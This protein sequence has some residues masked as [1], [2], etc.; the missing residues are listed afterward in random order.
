MARVGHLESQRSIKLSTTAV[1][2]LGTPHQG[3]RGVPI[4]QIVTRIMSSVSHTNPKLLDRMRPNSDWLLDLQYR[5]NAISQDFT[6]IYCYETLEM[7]LP[8]LGRLLL[9]LQIVPRYSAV[10]FG[11][12]NSEEVSFTADHSTIVKYHNL[13][14]PNFQKIAKRLQVLSMSATEQTRENWRVWEALKARPDPRLTTPLDSNSQSASQKEFDVGITFRAI[15][16]RHFTGREEILRLLDEMLVLKSTYNSFQMV[17]L[18]GPGGAGKTHIALEYARRHQTDYTSIH[19]IDGSREDV[20]EISVETCVNNIRRHYESHGNTESPRY[21]LLKDTSSSHARDN[22]FKW[23]SH[24]DNNSWLLIIDNVDDLESVNFRELLPSASAGRIIVTSRR[25]DLAINWDSIQIAT[26]EQHE[27]LALLQKSS[28]TV[29]IDGTKEFGNGLSLVHKLA[30]LPLAIVQ[31]GAHI[32]VH[33]F[34]NP[35][36]SYLDLYIKSPPDLLGDWPARAGWDTKEDTV[37]TTYEISFLSSDTISQDYFKLGD[38]FSEIQV[39]QA[40]GVLLSFS[41]L[42]E[43][44]VDGYY[45]MHPLIHLWARNRMSLQD[46]QTTGRKVLFMLRKHAAVVDDKFRP[47]AH[48][49]HLHSVYSSMKSHACDLLPEQ[50]VNLPQIGNGEILP[51]DLLTCSLLDKQVGLILWI[52]GIIGDVARFVFRRNNMERYYTSE[53]EIMYDLLNDGQI[54]RTLRYRREGG[55]ILAWIGCHAMKRFPTRHPR[56]LE[57]LGN[58]AYATMWT[59][60]GDE[61]LYSTDWYCS[62]SANWYAWLLRSRTQVL[63][64][65]HSATAGARLGLGL[66]FKNCEAAV[67][68]LITASKMRIKAA[69]FYD[70]LT[71]DTIESLART[72]RKCYDEST[73]FRSIENQSQLL[74]ALTSD[75]MKEAE[76]AIGWMRYEVDESV[77]SLNV[78]DPL[79]YRISIDLTHSMDAIHVALPFIVHLLKTNGWTILRVYPPWLDRLKHRFGDVLRSGHGETLAN[80]LRDLWE[81]ELTR[82]NQGRESNGRFCQ[83]GRIASYLTLWFAAAGDVGAAGLW[84]DR[85]YSTP[86]E[87]RDKQWH[88]HCEWP[89]KLSPGSSQVADL[90]DYRHRWGSPNYFKDRS[91]WYVSLQA[92]DYL[93]AMHR[94]AFFRSS[95]VHRPHEDWG[96]SDTMLSILFLT[97][98][99]NRA[100]ILDPNFANFLFLSGWKPQ[101]PQFQVDLA[102][103]LWDKHGK[104]CPGRV[105]RQAIHEAAHEDEERRGMFCLSDARFWNT[106]LRNQGD[107][108]LKSGTRMR[109]AGDGDF[110][111]MKWLPTKRKVRDVFYGA[112]AKHSA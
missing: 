8:F 75:N 83:M 48:V 62:H 70:T 85:I 112:K 99:L 20:I 41:L 56:V 109:T 94:P 5:Y 7:P 28:G 33:R 58:Y 59:R 63:G 16:N 100:A 40:F 39:R 27:A 97:P 51:H 82:N 19:W 73:M 87:P 36:T 18:Y 108:V 71:Y 34:H 38:Y 103:D 68:H 37:L 46:Q 101:L 2:F 47:P 45:S 1:I 57:I 89:I 95:D 50:K 6:A 93:K 14:D 86:N 13:E 61:C 77:I 53:W 49:I 98:G 79:V 78:T 104:S 84:L 66:S 96:S 92:R 23:L 9:A 64:E 81:Q 35:I 4:A 10:V 31:A 102:F 55:K 60:E 29:L 74:Q 90:G 105:L 88:E 15:W 80:V 22:Y 11:A 69:G 3:G 52:S 32:A 12:V 21:L 54:S 72:L 43:A 106:C 44:T 110:E 24:E 111:K 42:Q 67:S 65:D 17:V 26:M 30:Y 107:T 76:L 25:S 91:F